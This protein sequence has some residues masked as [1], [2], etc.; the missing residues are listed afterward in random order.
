[1]L[2]ALTALLA[3][4]SATTL[5]CARWSRLDL[6]QRRA[7]IVDMIEDA[8]ESQRGRGS[9]VRR[10]TLARCLRANA[11]EIARAFDD[12]CSDPRTAQ[13]QA[14]REVFETYLWSCLS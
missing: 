9:A 1:V 4:R 2:L 7:A 6:E 8:L 11:E 10:E 12:V 13:M 3:L 5:N 14:I